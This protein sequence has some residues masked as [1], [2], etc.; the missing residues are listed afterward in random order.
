MKLTPSSEFNIFEVGVAIFAIFIGVLIPYRIEYSQRELQNQGNCTSAILELRRDLANFYD[1]GDDGF[2]SVKQEPDQ[3]LIN[4]DPLAADQERSRMLTIRRAAQNSRD[5]VYVL[6]REIGDDN[7]SV[8]PANQP[9]VDS[10]LD[11]DELWSR[12]NISD[13]LRG[14]AVLID[15][16]AKI[17]P[18]FP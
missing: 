16:I 12:K 3:H 11:V 7:L 4:I 1:L 17:G 6:C 18:G 5:T 13:I 15:N 14:S 8:N 10:P 9:W 2:G